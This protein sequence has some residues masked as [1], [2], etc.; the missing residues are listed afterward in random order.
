MLISL[1]MT[2]QAKPLLDA[3]S[4]GTSMKSFLWAQ[5]IRSHVEVFREGLINE[6][7]VL[8]V[9]IKMIDHF[10]IEVLN[11]LGD[12]VG[13]FSQVESFKS[14]VFRM[15]SKVR[16]RFSL[17]HLVYSCSPVFNMVRLLDLAINNAVNI[18]GKGFKVLALRSLFNGSR[19][20]EQDNN[21]VFM[22]EHF[23]PFEFQVRDDFSK[24]LHDSLK[25]NDSGSFA[26]NNVSRVRSDSPVFSDSFV[27][28]SEVLGGLGGI[29]K[30][31]VIESVDGI[32]DSSEVLSTFVPWVVKLGRSPIVQH[33]VGGFSPIF[34]GPRPPDSLMLVFILIMMVF[35]VI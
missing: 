33:L 32:R 30:D 16:Y 15:E 4:E 9:G 6:G 26:S 13:M 28:Q 20:L 23:F 19:N 24:E 29:G 10:V 8:S 2:F 27:Q 22:D 12:S 14:D 21:L 31:L 3:I 5:T 17:D 1:Y 35:F 7:L 18:H 34:N 11:G 25:S